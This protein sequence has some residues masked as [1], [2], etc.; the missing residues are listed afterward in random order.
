[1][2]VASSPASTTVSVAADYLDRLARQDGLGLSTTAL[3]VFPG[4]CG[5]VRQVTIADDVCRGSGGTRR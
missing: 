1:M 5:H 2:V 4:S 3:R